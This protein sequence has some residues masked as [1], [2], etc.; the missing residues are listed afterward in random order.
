MK[1]LRA[2]I[3]GD[4]A[5]GN[6]GHGL[7]IAFTYFPTIKIMAVADPDAAGRVTLPLQVREHPFVR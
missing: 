2:A 7:D 6:Y 1:T 3:I 5:R 4:T